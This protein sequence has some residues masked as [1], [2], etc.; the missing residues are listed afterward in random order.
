[1]TGYL[2]KLENEKK[3]YLKKRERRKKKGNLCKIIF[4]ATQKLKETKK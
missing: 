1:V 3:Q 2:I 4:E